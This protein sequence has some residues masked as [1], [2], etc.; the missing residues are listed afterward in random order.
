MGESLHILKKMTYRGSS[1]VKSRYPKG[2]LISEVG[3]GLNFKR[4]KLL[5]ILE[6]VI[7]SEIQ[8]IV[9]AYPDRLVRFGFDLVVWM[10]EQFDCKV[11]VLNQVKL[12]PHQEL[13]QDMLAI[14]HNVLHGYICYENTKS[15]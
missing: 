12:S 13:V 6:R 15:L 9:I 5:H 3:S 4:K 10:C 11:T 2:E 7:K 14:M 8:E 1:F